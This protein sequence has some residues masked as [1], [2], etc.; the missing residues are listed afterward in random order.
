MNW[1]NGLQNAVDYIEDHLT[2]ELDYGDIAAQANY[3]SFYFQRVFGIL[4]ECT[5][6]EYIRKRRLTLAG[7]ELASSDVKVIDIALKYGYDSPESFGRA[8]T[9]FHGIT[10]VQAKADSVNL[11]SYSRLS[12]KLIMDGGSTM[13]Y[14]IEKKEAFEVIVK[15]KR[16]VNDM[17]A[18]N[19]QLP[20]FWDSCWKDQTMQE[21]FRQAPGDGVFGNALAGLCIHEDEQDDEFTYAIGTS[22][23]GGPVAEGL[24]VEKV[25]PHTWAIFEC[26][27][28]MPGAFQ[29]LLRKIYS[30]FFPSSEYQPCGSSDIQVYPQGDMQSPGYTCQL[31]IPIEISYEK[32]N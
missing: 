24:S 27:G 18:S 20:R 7:S 21:L 2:E 6:G 17:E 8:F 23:C 1:I 28:P 11:K 31:W 10:P 5:L 19:R 12:V 13:K 14:R 26:T 30:E 4:C 25:P 22:Y 3:S 16:F 32:M 9:R 29:E 15:K